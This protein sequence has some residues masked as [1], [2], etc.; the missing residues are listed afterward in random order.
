V[1][2]TEPVPAFNENKYEYSAVLFSSVI[3]TKFSTIAMLE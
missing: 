3:S 2:A 1:P